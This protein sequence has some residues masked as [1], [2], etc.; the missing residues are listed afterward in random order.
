LL[1]TILSNTHPDGAPRIV[2]ASRHV[3][4]SLPKAK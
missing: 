1:E 3:P 2:S 4:I